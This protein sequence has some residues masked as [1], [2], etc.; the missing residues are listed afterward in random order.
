M[1]R[2]QF[3]R[4][5]RAYCRSSGL[6]AP[7]FEGHHGKGGH[8]RIYVGDRFTTARSGEIGKG[9]HRAMLGQLGLP[10]DAF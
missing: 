6:P 5:L 4:N 1:N 2:D 7:V 8:G 3:L 9:L 10:P